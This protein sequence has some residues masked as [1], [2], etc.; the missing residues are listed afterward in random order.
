MRHGCGK[1]NKETTQTRTPNNDKRYLGRYFN[2]VL[3]PQLE[4]Y[5]Y[6]GQEPSRTKP[7]HF[8]QTYMLPIIRAHPD[9]EGQSVF[10]YPDETYDDGT[11]VSPSTEEK[12]LWIMTRAYN[13]YKNHYRNK[14]VKTTGGDEGS[15]KTARRTSRLL[16]KATSKRASQEEL[17]GKKG[18]VQKTA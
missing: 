9:F 3:R 15:S 1:Y 7:K 11:R 13:W 10:G 14:D 5:C 6:A 8:V 2:T 16:S 4:P 18:R 12:I 17:K